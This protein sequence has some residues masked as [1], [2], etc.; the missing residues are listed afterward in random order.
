MTEGALAR[1]D[2]WRDAKPG[3]APGPSGVARRDPAG[4][5]AQRPRLLIADDEPSVL[6]VLE[7]LGDRAGYDVVSCDGGEAAVR[8]L[9]EQPPDLALVDLRMPDLDGMEVLRQLRTEVPWCAAVIMTAYGAV[10]SAVEA[11]KLGAREYITK[12]FDFP[13]LRQLL[14]DVRDEID[15]RRM[16]ASPQTIAPSIDLPA[17]LGDTPVTHEVSALVST[18]AP[19]ARVVLITGESGSGTEI[20]A[21]AFHESGPRR[22]KPFVTINCSALVDALFERELFG[23]ERGAF[24]G[25]EDGKPGLFEAAQGGTVFLDDVAELPLSVQATL[26][27][28]LDTGA[29]RRVG[30]Q[31][32]R[33]VDVAMVAAT[34]R[35]LRADVAAGRFRADLYYRLGVV[36][37]VVPPLRERRDD[38]PL[39][40][41]TFLRDSASR[42]GK[43]LTGFSDDAMA[44]LREA[45]WDGN[46]R[47]LRSCVER[48]CARADDSVVSADDIV[49]AQGSE[50]GAS[51][52][53][54]NGL[55]VVRSGTARGPLQDV[56][57]E[58]ILSVLRDV[59]GN[60]V[61]AA[62]VLGISRRALYRRLARHR[63]AEETL[64]AVPPSRPADDSHHD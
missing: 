56:E 7:R 55:H 3:D 38:I 4:P 57:K 12:P 18:L 25:A 1:R 59:R 14:T 22:A 50:T 8:A 37:I 40:A 35:D 48:A 33:T 32:T 20:I 62:R 11:M 27:Q 17:V 39:I 6:Q 44:L 19:S 31:H 23:H 36:G 5:G 58:H 9:R 60:R 52:L 46:V 30:A 61:A 49:A 16:P 10:D 29:I 28:T 63:I 47:E 26:L 42:L 2:L 53:R 51:P 24:S 54:A 21:R 15:E 34:R 45:S 64:R 13:Q 41:T 43:L